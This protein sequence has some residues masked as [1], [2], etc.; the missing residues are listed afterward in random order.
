V[1]RYLPFVLW[2]A[3]TVVLL[4]TITSDF[5]FGRRDPRLWLMRM[6][7]AL[8]WPLAALSRAGRDI[9]FRNGRD[10]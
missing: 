8:I 10:L 3:I 9:L 1:V 5:I 6:G 4:V 2:I 7:L